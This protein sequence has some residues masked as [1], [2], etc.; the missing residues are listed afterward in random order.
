MSIKLECFIIT[1]NYSSLV[2]P[3]KA[4]TPHLV[5]LTSNT[6]LGWKCNQTTN[7]PS[8]RSKVTDENVL[9]RRPVVE[10]GSNGRR[11]DATTP[12]EF[13]WPP[14]PIF[15]FLS[16]DRMRIAYINLD[17][18]YYDAQVGRPT[19]QRCERGGRKRG[20]RVG[21]FVPVATRGYKYFNISC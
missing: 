14:G 7:A 20:V 8:C 1:N 19:C 21:C 13:L 16:T 17:A 18:L 9:Y 15:F 6:R 2:L 12:S 5:E 4:D 10:K 3:S 11:N